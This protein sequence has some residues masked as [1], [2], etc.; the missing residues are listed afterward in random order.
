MQTT[1]EKF[2]ALIAEEGAEAVI[3]AI[4]GHVHPETSGNCPQVPCPNGYYCSGG[5]CLL[6]VGNHG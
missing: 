1:Q 3:A 4:K 2:D 5:N 6:D